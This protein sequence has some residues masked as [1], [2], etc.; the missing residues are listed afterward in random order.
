MV[1]DFPA[2]TKN[3]TVLHRGLAADLDTDIRVHFRS[4]DDASAP[5]NVIARKHYITVDG[6]SGGQGAFGQLNIPCKCK[7]M[8]LSSAGSSGNTARF[9]IHADL[10]GIAPAQMFE[11]TGSGI[12]S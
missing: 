9:E 3:I 5:N 10:T 6:P 11:L 1:I 7:R 8:Y 12:T 2:V 4:K